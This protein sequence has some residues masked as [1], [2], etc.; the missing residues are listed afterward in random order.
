MISPSATL[1]Y[2]VNGR[3]FYLMDQNEIRL[4]F[5]FMMKEQ[6][7]EDSG[8]DRGD[9][10]FF[11]DTVGNIHEELTGKRKSGELPFFD[12]PYQDTSRIKSIAKDISHRYDN[13]LLDRK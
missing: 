7:G 5:N 4:D 10:D 8:I 1:A 6:I 12:L 13:F 3:R 2:R 9:I 11:S